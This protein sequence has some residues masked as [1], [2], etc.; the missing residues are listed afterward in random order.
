[1]NGQHFRP[2]IDDFILVAH[3]LDA[4]QGFSQKS[5]ALGSVLCVLTIFEKDKAR[6]ELVITLQ[7]GSIYNVNEGLH[8]ESVIYGALLDQMRT[9]DPLYA[10]RLL[11]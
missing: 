9:E 3:I 2:V 1:M 7:Q 6:L 5:I 8:V 11:L 10:Q 4:L